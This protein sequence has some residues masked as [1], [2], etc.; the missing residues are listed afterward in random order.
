MT[1][2]GYLFTTLN[3][4]CYCLSRFMKQ[5]KTMLLL[6][7]LSKVLTV[8]GLYCLDSLSG[9][10]V[11]AGVFFLL[12]VANIKER[13]NKRWLLGYVFF[14]GLYLFILFYTYV[15][16]SSVL[17]V[18]QVSI[19]LFC[20]WWLSPQKM[21]VIGGLNSFTCLAYQISIKNWAGLLE[22]FVIFSNFIAFL[23]YK[24]SMLN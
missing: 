13:L 10:Y 3:Y 20:I 22:I 17:V 16:I 2:L 5:K 9:A 7:L 14:Q 4:G 19:N 18:L 6:D 15:G 12:I 11:F 23:K 8:L 24:K 21:R 1:L